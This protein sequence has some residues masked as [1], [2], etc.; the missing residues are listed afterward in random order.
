MAVVEITVGAQGIAPSFRL[1][2][3]QNLLVDASAKTVPFSD[4]TCLT[5][6]RGIKML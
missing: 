6:S 3:G 1:G 4:L 2:C 5:F